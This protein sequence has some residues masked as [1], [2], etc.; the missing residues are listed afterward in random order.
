MLNGPKWQT[1]HDVAEDTEWSQSHH[2]SQDQ[3]RNNKMHSGLVQSQ[4]QEFWR[5]NTCGNGNHSLLDLVPR[6]I[7]HRQTRQSNCSYCDR[8]Q[9]FEGLSPIHCHCGRYLGGA[10]H[11]Q[12]EGSFNY[13]ANVTFPPMSLGSDFDNVTFDLLPGYWQLEFLAHFLDLGVF[14]SPLRFRFL[15]SG[16]CREQWQ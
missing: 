10:C 15:K 2:C 4:S 12:L 13:F 14:S 7:Y 11:S 8:R 6:K 9:Q 1:C 5:C 16:V 3:N